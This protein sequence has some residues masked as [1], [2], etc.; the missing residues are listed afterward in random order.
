[1]K[2]RIDIFGGGTF[3]HVRNH[4]ALAAPAF[5]ETARKL[6]LR[7]LKKFPEM[8]VRIHLT[9]MADPQ[10]SKIVTNNDVFE[11]LNEVVKDPLA[12]VVIFNPA[13]CDFSGNVVKDKTLTQSGKYAKRLKSREVDWPHICLSPEPKLIPIIRQ[14]RPD[15]ILV[16]FKTTCNETEEEMISAAVSTKIN[17]DAQFVWVNDT[18]TRKNMLYFECA[19]I[20][21]AREECGIILLDKINEILRHTP[22]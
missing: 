15:I 13:L 22:T 20:L 7:S 14:V 10:N 11:K 4:L 17:T 21:L 6:Y 3:S 8:D 5:G 9:K 1:M 2:K 18:G 12:K 16:A 19:P